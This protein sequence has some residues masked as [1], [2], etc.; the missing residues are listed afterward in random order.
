VA[1]GAEAEQVLGYAA[2]QSGD[3]GYLLREG[4]E[5]GV[6]G[7]EGGFAALYRG[8]EVSEGGGVGCS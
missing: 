1:G 8:E 2:V 3:V 4:F 6:V 5:L 7:A